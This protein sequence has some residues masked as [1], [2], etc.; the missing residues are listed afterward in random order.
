M[1]ALGLFSSLSIDMLSA[2]KEKK[3]A[4]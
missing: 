1:G 3:K 4:R 2:D